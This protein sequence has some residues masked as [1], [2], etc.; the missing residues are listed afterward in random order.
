[1]FA[2][3]LLHDFE[4]GVWKSVFIHLIRILYTLGVEKVQI[5]NQRCIFTLQFVST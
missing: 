5:L 4:L 1:M 3:D 2:V